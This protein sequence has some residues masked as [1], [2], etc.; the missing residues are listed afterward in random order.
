MSVALLTYRTH[1]EVW[2]RGRDGCNFRQDLIS[3]GTDG[4][5]RDVLKVEMINSLHQKA[6]LNRKNKSPKTQKI[7]IQKLKK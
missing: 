6:V 5:V 1:N 3:R 4:I 7:A 2:L